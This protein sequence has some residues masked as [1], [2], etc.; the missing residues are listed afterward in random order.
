MN[1]RQFIE[2]LGLGG[3]LG[4]AGCTQGENTS[5]AS[6][7]VDPSF[8]SSNETTVFDEN[9]SEENQEE[10]AFFPRG[11][12][13]SGIEKYGIWISH[14]SSEINDPPSRQFEIYEAGF[15][16]GQEEYKKAWYDSESKKARIVRSGGSIYRD[17][18]F[19][20]GVKFEKRGKVKAEDIG[21]NDLSLV[22]DVKL[23]E[24]LL[25]SLP[26]RH[27]STTDP[28]KGVLPAG[29]LT[30]PSYSAIRPADY[31]GIEGV[32]YGVN[33]VRNTVLRDYQGGELL[34]PATNRFQSA[35]GH[36][37][38][39][40]DG[41]PAQF[42]IELVG[43]SGSDVAEK[44]VLKKNIVQAG[45]ISVPEPEWLEKAKELLET[46]TPTTANS[47]ASFPLKIIEA[48]GDVESGE[49]ATIT[50]EVENTGEGKVD[51]SDLKFSWIHQEAAA[52]YYGS[53]ADNSHFTVRNS[54][55]VAGSGGTELIVVDVDAIQ[56]GLGEEDTLKIMMSLG[57]KGKLS[58]YFQTP[59]INDRS[60]V[61]LH[62]YSSE[63]SS[64]T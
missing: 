34:G 20:D 26:R 45:G 48:T 2:S 57:H 35:S 49:I 50:F 41:L 8:N 7:V 38:I 11:W 14:L 59:L 51:L 31:Q 62:L 12:G 32:L 43:N 42:N 56:G 3:V 29:R 37:F 36:L 47:K 61:K 63:Y 18:Y 13:E 55:V 28:N 27:P 24:M 9:A 40:R 4:L 23:N 17:V 6:D 30:I 54:S 58:A 25:R 64:N 16:L 15:L 21:V 33:G 60:S 53:S 52:L 39:S 1:R 10:I 19:V 5:H 46:P 22:S 44:S